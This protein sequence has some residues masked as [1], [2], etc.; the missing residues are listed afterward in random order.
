M[1]LPENFQLAACYSK[2]DTEL[3]YFNSHDQIV[4]NIEREINHQN[5]RTQSD[6]NKGEYPRLYLI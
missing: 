2:F 3:H 4:F 5:S 1:N 6:S